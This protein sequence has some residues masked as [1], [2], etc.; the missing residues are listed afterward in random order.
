[1]GGG[2]GKNAYEMLD[3]KSQ[4]RATVQNTLLVARNSYHPICISNTN[5]SIYIY[6]KYIY[7]IPLLGANLSK[8]KDLGFFREEV[9]VIINS[10]L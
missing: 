2:K 3:L 9:K 10:C 1:M 8:V 4:G 6:T 7:I 5:E